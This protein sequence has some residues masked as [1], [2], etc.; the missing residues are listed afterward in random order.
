MSQPQL[1]PTESDSSG[2]TSPERTHLW[3][4]DPEVPQT[5]A[6]TEQVEQPSELTRLSSALTEAGAP[7]AGGVETAIAEAGPNISDGHVNLSGSHG[8]G[9]HAAGGFSYVANTGMQ[10]HMRGDLQGT[11]TGFSAFGPQPGINQGHSAYWSS[12][13]GMAP[14]TVF[15]PRMIG[16]HGF[17]PASMMHGSPY[18]SMNAGPGGPY[19]GSGASVYG[20]GMPGFQASSAFTGPPEWSGA[21]FGM[22]TERAWSTDVSQLSKDHVN[23]GT[24]PSQRDMQTDLRSDSVLP[25]ANSSTDSE[26]V[27]LQKKATLP[28]A[29]EGAAV[30]HSTPQKRALT[31]ED[32]AAMIEAR[33]K[34][35]VH[36]EFGNM[37]G[38]GVS[39]IVPV[40]IQHAVH[41]TMLTLMGVQ[42]REPGPTG[43][44]TGWLLPDPLEPSAAPREAPDE[45]RTRLWNPEWR[46]EG[47]APG[48]NREFL[49][50][51][52]KLVQQNAA[53]YGLTPAM[54]QRIGLIQRASLVYFNTLKRKYTA[55]HEEEAGRKRQKKI[56]D[57]KQH[58]RRHRSAD[59]LRLGFDALRKLFGK[60]RTVGLE[61]VVCTPCQSDEAS[62]DGEVTHEVREEHRVKARVGQRAL[63][64]RTPGWRSRK[65]TILYIVLAVLVRFIR[66]REPLTEPKQRPRTRA[67]TRGAR[68]HASNDGE[69][70]APLSDSESDSEEVRAARR[71]RVRDAVKDWSTIYVHPNQRMERFRGPPENSGQEPRVNK[72]NTIYKEFISRKWADKS[73]KNLQ[74]YED[75]PSCPSTFT[76]FDLDGLEDLI[77]E[78]DLGWLGDQEDEGD[79]E[80]VDGADAD[81]GGAL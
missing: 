33:A 54:A 5:A 79:A 42:E 44:K 68:R 13:P 15:D 45:A 18:A 66:E 12:N 3:A 52:V 34:E 1:Q 6:R 53:M 63:E 77:P 62:S 73:D 21:Q 20:I 64:V 38:K 65:L 56:L 81:D 11:P 17:N 41:E 40:Q 32:V 31:E 76:I 26:W 25:L 67:R 36:E 59:N 69:E 39:E 9:N 29:L 37:R 14:H 24:Q 43:R 61:Q 51:V 10:G 4:K 27:S 58:S 2:I 8:A 47:N 75:A 60:S 71:A 22:Q 35:I 16:M 78:D 50:A 57:D 55:D 72:K 48:V 28:S 80:L 49:K 23:E 19:P 74:F 46:R 7:S 70:E 30:E